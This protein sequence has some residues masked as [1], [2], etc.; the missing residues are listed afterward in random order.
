VKNPSED[1]IAAEVKV[2]LTFYGADGPTVLT[3][4]DTIAYILPGET[5]ATGNGEHVPLALDLAVG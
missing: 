2:N 4:Q 1:K 3:Q 5:S